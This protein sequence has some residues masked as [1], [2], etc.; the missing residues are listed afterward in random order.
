MKIVLGADS[1]LREKQWS[2][3]FDE[4]QVNAKIIYT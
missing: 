4:K 2:I 3:K 1:K